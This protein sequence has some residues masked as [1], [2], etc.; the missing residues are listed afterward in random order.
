MRMNGW[1]WFWVVVA[2]VVVTLF[3]VQAPEIVRYV[4][5]KRM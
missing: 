1:S 2:A 4:K 3:A 5:I